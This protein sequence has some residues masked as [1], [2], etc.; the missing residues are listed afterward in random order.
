M[1][2]NPIKIFIEKFSRLP[3]VGPRLATKL[4]LHLA[5][6]SENDFNEI[7]N[8]LEKYQD[9][10]RC[11]YCFSLKMKNEEY[12]KLCADNSRKREMIA[13]VEKETDVEAIEESGVYRGL[14]LIIGE[15][16]HNGILPEEQKNRL[17]VFKT[18]IT[19]KKRE[20]KEVIIALP[21]NT[22]GDFIAETIRQGLAGI[23]PKITRLG[24]GIPTGG[25]IEF[26]D[27]ETLKG[28]IEKRS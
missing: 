27:E 7:K 3:S 10:N 26:A 22:Y 25:T 20:V 11:S 5:S 4:A 15:V 23:V 16:P 13:I 12:C 24:R 17:R 1:L 28:A 9:L 6:L 2:P 14:Y 19:E 21:Q 18:S 8:A